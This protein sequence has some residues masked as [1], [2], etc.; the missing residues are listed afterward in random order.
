MSWWMLSK[1]DSRKRMLKFLSGGNGPAMRRRN[2]A[3]V[4]RERTRGG[5]V[6]SLSH[7]PVV[8]SW[9]TSKCSIFAEWRC[10]MISPNAV[11]VT[12]PIRPCWDQ[13][14]ATERT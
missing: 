11:S 14:T 12:P 2:A 6:I 4:S 1:S 9:K 10:F 8:D 3:E 5:R 7:V 13:E